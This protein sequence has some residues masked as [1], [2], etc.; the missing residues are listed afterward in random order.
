MPQFICQVCEEAFSLPNAALDNYPGWEPKYCQKHSPNKRKTKVAGAKKR[1]SGGPA[2]GVFTDGG[3][4]PNPGRGGWGFVW[5]EENEIISEKHGSESKTT[6]NRM[7]LTALVEAYR[8]LPAD[9]SVPVFTDSKLC[10]PTARSHFS[11]SFV[12][13]LATNA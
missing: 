2:T 3:A 4:R 6:N 5:V 10:A 11:S 1:A 13:N 12:R 7:E 8:A 9:A